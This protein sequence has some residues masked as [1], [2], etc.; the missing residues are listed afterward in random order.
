MLTKDERKI[1]PSHVRKFVRRLKRLNDDQQGE[2]F[3]WHN[4]REK[5]IDRVCL[6]TYRCVLD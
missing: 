2:F 5:E 1:T 6:A 4:E 3:D